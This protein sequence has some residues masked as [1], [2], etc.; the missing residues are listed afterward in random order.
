MLVPYACKHRDA[1]A[2]RTVANCA[3]LAWFVVQFLVLK[4]I[5]NRSRSQGCILVHLCFLFIATALSS[6][7]EAD[8]L[9]LLLHLRIARLTARVHRYAYIT[10]L[11]CLSSL[12]VQ[13]TA[14]DA[15]HTLVTGQWQ[16]LPCEEAGFTMFQNVCACCFCTLSQ[17]E[18]L[19]YI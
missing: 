7:Q 8:S 3:A 18:H 1:A 6:F 10:W 19:P 5:L 17:Y 9:L 11:S 16:V 14:S 4:L 2:E 13:P 15:V 12:T